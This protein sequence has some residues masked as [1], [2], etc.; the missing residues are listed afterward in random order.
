MLGSDLFRAC[1]FAGLPL[2]TNHSLVKSLSKCLKSI[3]TQN[4]RKLLSHLPNISYLKEKIGVHVIIIRV[5]DSLKKSWERGTRLLFVK[6]YIK[7]SLSY[8]DTGKRRRKTLFWC[9]YTYLPGRCS[10]L[11]AA[12][13]MNDTK[14][15][16]ICGKIISCHACG[17]PIFHRYCTRSLMP[18]IWYSGKCSL[19]RFLMRL[20]TGNEKSSF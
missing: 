14:V 16:L 7:V 15:R 8:N 2:P 5:R 11:G 3:Q 18:H 13:F 10:M 17:F 4:T 1:T 12:D 19:E 6:H 20:W 9:I